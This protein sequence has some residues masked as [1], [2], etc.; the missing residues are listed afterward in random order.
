MGEVLLNKNN[1]VKILKEKGFD[2]AIE[3]AMVFV[4]YDD[5]HSIDTLPELVAKEMEKMNYG[6]SYGVKARDKK[7]KAQAAESCADESV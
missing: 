6:S 2:A 4:Y 3:D 1:A 7:D 5:R